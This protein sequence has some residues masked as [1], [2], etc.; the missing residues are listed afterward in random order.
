[1][2]DLIREL[3]LTASKATAIGNNKSGL[4]TLCKRLV[5]KHSRIS[6]EPKFVSKDVDRGN[7]LEPHARM[8]YMLKTSENVKQI[9]FVVHSKHVGCSPDGFVGEDGLIEIKCPNDDNYGDIYLDRKIKSDYIWQMQMQMLVC[10]KSWCDYVA[11]NPNYEDDLVIIRQFPIKEK[12]DALLE[13][14]KIGEK[15]ILQYQKEW[16]NKTCY[17]K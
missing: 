10:E 1:V 11:Y 9:G 14:F 4:V 2:W 8:E 7:T 12:F 3:R 17:S 5:Q 16:E 13:G 15:L 6:H